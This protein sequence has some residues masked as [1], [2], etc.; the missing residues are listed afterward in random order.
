M[1]FDCATVKGMLTMHFHAFLMGIP[2]WAGKPGCCRKPFEE[3]AVWAGRGC[4]PLTLK[5][6]LEKRSCAG[7]NGGNC[8]AS[9]LQISVALAVGVAVA[10]SKYGCEH[11]AS[12]H[13][14]KYGKN[15]NGRMVAHQLLALENG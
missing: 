6:C 1:A 13:S 5:V 7:C 11:G 8:R 15:E 4:G 9:Q 3:I 10:G 12:N 2:L 14:V